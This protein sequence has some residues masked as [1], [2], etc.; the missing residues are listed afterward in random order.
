MARE[1]DRDL[2]GSASGSVPKQVNDLTSIVKKKRKAPEPE[3]PQKDAST[4]PEKKSKVEDA[5]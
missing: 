2:N 5:A 3:S 1:L 4:P